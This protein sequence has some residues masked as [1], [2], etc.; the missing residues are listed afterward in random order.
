MEKQ[1]RELGGKTIQEECK[2]E[3]RRGTF[4]YGEVCKTSAGQL[5]CRKIYHIALYEQW[6]STCKLS[7][8]VRVQKTNSL[9]LIWLTVVA[10]F[11]LIQI[12]ANNKDI[13]K[14]VA[15]NARM[16]N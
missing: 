13:Y 15:Q 14:S 1:I 4:T 11:A 2:E 10:S 9:N 5:Q 8:E 16:C 6:I 3:R 12:H 7:L